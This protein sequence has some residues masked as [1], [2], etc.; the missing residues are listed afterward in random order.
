M[1]ENL[2][3]FPLDFH[4]ASKR[5]KRRRKWTWETKINFSTSANFD[6]EN[7]FFLF[8]LRAQKH[9]EK[10]FTLKEFIKTWLYEKRVFLFRFRWYHLLIHRVFPF[11]SFN[12][13]NFSPS[14]VFNHPP[15]SFLHFHRSYFWRNI[16]LSKNNLTVKAEDCYRQLPRTR[17]E[18]SRCEKWNFHGWVSNASNH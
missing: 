6:L 14:F 10:F 16:C 8:A 11:S 17:A 2:W 13:E 4:V 1:C 12:L 9:C 15:L 18:R 7:V 3:N 5:K